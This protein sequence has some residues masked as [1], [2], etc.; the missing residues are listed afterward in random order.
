MKV[1][2][3]ANVEK[4]G[5]AGEVKEVKN[6]FG[7]NYLIPRKLAITASAKSLS[8]L[9]HHR[10]SITA[11]ETR[12]HKDA[13]TV[14]QSIERLSITIPCKVGEE[15]K[16]FGSVTAMDIA[17]ALKEKQIEI[18]KRQ[19]RLEEP[20]RTLGVYT[21]PIHLSKDVEARLKLWLVK[22]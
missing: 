6:G 10:K 11:Q 9:D 16:L 15:D 18:D 4:L 22:E 7:R 1:I 21:I 19:I 2:L 14:K 17:Q 5:K 3:L 13:E 12:R 20:L 8:Q